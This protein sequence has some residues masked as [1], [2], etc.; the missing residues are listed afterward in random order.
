MRRVLSSIACGALG[1]LLGATARQL[2][3][4]RGAGGQPDDELVVTVPV[5]ATA[6][7]TLVGIVAG[8]KAAFLSGLALGA[9][10]GKGLD[11]FVPG[12]GRLG[13]RGVAVAPQDAAPAG[14]TT[15]PASDDAS[16]DA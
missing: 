4:R 3:C 13:E 8:R 1:G 7:A 5:G 15:P 6:A 16:R 14:G 11:R 10:V 9:A 2:T 12:L